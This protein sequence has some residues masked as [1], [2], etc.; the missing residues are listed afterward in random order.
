[1]SNAYLSHHA[2]WG[3]YA[4]FILGEFGKGGGFALSDV[5]SPG[6]SVYVAYRRSGEDVQVLPFLSAPLGLGEFA[7]QADADGLGHTPPPTRSVPGEELER[8]LG[9]A[10][11]EW[12]HGPLRF[13]LLSPFGEVPT[14]GT[15]DAA[16]KRAVCP[17][18][19]AELELDN[20]DSANRAE[21]LFAL[22]GVNRPLSDTT[23]GA[24]LGAAAGRRWGVAALPGPDVEEVQDFDVIGAAFGERRPR[25]RRLG[26]AGGVRLTVPPGQVGRLVLALGSYQGG[27]VT[28]G[29][30][31]QFFYTEMF[32][33]LEEVLA[34]GLEHA[35]HYRQL[36]ADRDAELRGSGLSCERQ[37][38]LA[39]AAHG[40]LANTELLVRE[41]GRP[42]WVV[43]E[44]EYRMMNTL[45]LTIDQLFWELRY[46]PW[47]SGNVLDLFLERYAFTDAVQGSGGPLP[48]GLSFPHDVGVSNVF[49]P[50]GLSSYETEDLHGCFSHMTFEQLT[51]WA[52]SA[53]V[54]GRLADPA[55]LTRRGEV[56]EACLAS[57]LARDTDGDGVMDVDSARCGTGTEITTY[58]SLDASLGPARGN[59]YLA[60]KTWAALVC[61]EQALTALGRG[62]ERAR[63]QAQRAAARIAGAFDPA[64]G[65]IPALLSGGSDACII[66]A[67]EAL[68]YPLLLGLREAVSETGPYGPLVARLRQHL[69]TALQPGRCLDPV[70]GG[71]K[72]SSTSPNTWMSKI[73]LCQFVAETVFGLAP[74]PHCDAAHVRWQQLGSAAHGPTDQ[75]RS[76]DGH[77]LGSRLYPRL[78]TAVLWLPLPEGP[79][80]PRW[81]AALH[82]PVS[83]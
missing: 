68:V 9:W 22:E 54:Y 34:F 42:L 74:D 38:L 59:L 45:D 47:T 49:S 62:G 20:R 71:W 64:L 24:L 69:Q 73:F 3:A 43:N 15:D 80:L 76:T 31:A 16:L 17:V 6:R 55:W 61:L 23:A 81:E 66:P 18:V 4:P 7:Y 60:V 67:V 35:G 83:S 44:G 41:G 37:F 30:N 27:T 63:Q 21:L 26:N 14:P 36:A 2:P 5:H 1:M 40:Y 77:A 75:V 65:Y 46:H 12:R 57:L 8:H 78:V 79:S 58:D 28:A 56:L 52:L 19:L 25:V 10:S 29:L 82:S 39:H 53:A 51:N 13:R 11:D 32:A 50:P 70:S 33:D 72:L 48:G